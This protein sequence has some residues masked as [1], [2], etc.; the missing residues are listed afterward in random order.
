LLIMVAAAAMLS[1]ALIRPRG[2]KKR[3]ASV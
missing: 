1:V 2:A 3:G